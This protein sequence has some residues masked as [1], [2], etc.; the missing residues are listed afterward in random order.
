VRHLTK[1][2]WNSTINGTNYPFSMSYTDAGMP[3]TMTYPDGTVLTAS[4]TSQG[5][6]SA[7]T[8]NRNGTN[9]T[10]VS[11]IGY[12]GTGGAAMEPTSASIGNSTYLHRHGGVQHPWRRYD[13]PWSPKITPRTCRTISA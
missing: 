12:T 6:P 9:T 3:S 11:A 4:Y 2:G 8:V 5:W 10:L 13:A 1:E 7:A